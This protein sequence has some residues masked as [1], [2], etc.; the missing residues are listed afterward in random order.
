[1][2]RG[3][4][5]LGV[6]ALITAVCWLTTMPFYTTSLLKQF[7]QLLGAFALVGFACANYISTRHCPLN[8]LFNGLDKAYI[9]HKWL[10]ITSL[11]LAVAHLVTLNIGRHGQGPGQGPGRGAEW[12][13]VPVHESPLVHIGGPCLALFVVLILLAL[14]AKRMNYER[15]KTLH[16]IMVLPYV[17]GVLHY[18]GS[19]SYGAFDVSPFS[20]WLNCVNVIGIVSAVYSIFL[21]EKIAFP[22]RYKV[23]GVQSVAKETV[24]I[25]GRAIGKGMIYKPGQFTF[26]KFPG[27]NIRFPSHP[28]TLNGAP[29]SS[30]Q[31]EGVHTADAGIQFTV[32]NLGDHTAKMITAVKTGDEFAVTAPHGMFDYTTGGPRQVW[33]AGGIGVTPFRSFYL[34]DIPEDFSIDFFYA[35]HGEEEGAYLDEMRALKKSNLRMHLIDD[36]QQGFLTVEKMEKYLKGIKGDRLHTEAPLEK[37]LV[38]IYF[39]GPKPMRDTLLKDISKRWRGADAGKNPKSNG[40]CVAGLHFEE[41]Q[42][43]R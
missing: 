8:S 5:A 18:Y 14:V 30:A 4:I 9:A 15:W 3:N 35:Y 37:A 24:E 26:V 32:K 20:I 28:F 38:D 22:Y 39:C 12:A 41:F 27:K 10:G 42:F 19:S 16:K 7:S 25:T 36:T 23:S 6:I 29:Q 21:Y 31:Q 2:K 1:M 13:A 40:M 17:F 11:G 43:G 33:I 34:A